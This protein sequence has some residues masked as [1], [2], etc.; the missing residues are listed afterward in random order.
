MKC[1]A[2]VSQAAAVLSAFDMLATAAGNTTSANA[3][4][5]DDFMP[6]TT[7][8]PKKL[9]SKK[10]CGV[11]TLLTS[12]EAI[13]DQAASAA[14]ANVKHAVMQARPSNDISAAYG[15]KRQSEAVAHESEEGLKE[16]HL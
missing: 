16:S 10:K 11:A 12:D 1:D 4:S 6:V 9:A 15:E 7:H 13:A 5:P 14:A 8:M 3:T 2:R